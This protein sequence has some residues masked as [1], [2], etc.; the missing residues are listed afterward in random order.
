[1]VV[2]PKSFCWLSGR[3][4]QRRD[5]ATW[6]EELRLLPKLKDVL[7]DAGVGLCRGIKLL[8]AQQPEL[9]HGLDVFHTKLEG[10]KAIRRDYGAV[11]RPLEEATQKQAE[12]EKLQRQG[13]RP[14]R[15]FMVAGRCWRR[16]EWLLDQA[17]TRERAWKEV[18]AALELFT[19]EGRLNDR[20]QAAAKM[21]AALPHLEGKGWAKTRGLLKRPQTL[22]FLDRLQERVSALG[23]SQK[24]LT[25]LERLEGLRRQPERCRGESASAAAARGLALISAVQ[26]AK[27]DA[28]WPEKMARF[29]EVLQQTLRA[30]SPV[31]GV[32]SVMRM[33]QARHRR[34]S[35]GL[36]DLKRL[37][38]NLRPFR[39]GGRKGRSPYE[40]L[41]VSLPTW[42][43]W[44]LVN[45]PMDELRQTLSVQKDGP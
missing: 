26:L 16:A 28:Q 7:S 31:E 25:A 22:T 5:G 10:N 39:T 15:Q 40:I 35:Q 6:L 41:G 32:N 30:S 12:A 14:S 43:W 34:M 8:A 45:M 38:W 18:C 21:G 3:L 4:A 17:A 37:Y 36:L 2:E 29:R 27:S 1:M 11:S 44:D 42:S 23:Y 33:Q 13:R 24:T 9:R 19:P 20:Q